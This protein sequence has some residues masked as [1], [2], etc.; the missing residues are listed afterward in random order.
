[1][2]PRRQRAKISRK[3]PTWVPACETRGEGIFFQFSES[4][5]QEW[6]KRNHAYEREF[7]VGHQA[8]RATK[9][10]DPNK[11]YPGIRYVLVAHVFPR[12]DSP[13]GHRVRLHER[14]DHRADLFENPADG[15]PMAGVLIYTSA[16]TAKER[17]VACVP[18]ANRT[19]S[20]GTFAGR[21]RR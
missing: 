4:L 16:P 1:M 18:S 12:L 14:L 3:D 6:V 10:L 8:W 11:G 19:S 5:I 13:I 15:D 7:E 9:N 17:W 20:V 2:Y 21:W